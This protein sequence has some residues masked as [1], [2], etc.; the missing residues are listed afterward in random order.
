MYWDGFAGEHEDQANC[1]KPF[2][3]RSGAAHLH[4]FESKSSYQTLY[5]GI[6]KGEIR[7]QHEARSGMLER[8]GQ[9]AAAKGG[10]LPLSDKQ[11]YGEFVEDLKI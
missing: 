10:A 8:I 3:E 7:K 11:R 6:S 9:L 5:G 1:C 2:G 4:A